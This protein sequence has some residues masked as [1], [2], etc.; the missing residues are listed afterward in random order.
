MLHKKFLLKSV[1]KKCGQ[2]LISGFP[3]AGKST[4]I[5]K[6][7]DSKISIVSQKIQTTNQT[8]RGV[9][10]KNNCQLIFYDTPGIVRQKKYFSKKLSR[11]VFNNSESIDLNLFVLDSTLKIN[12][13][14]IKNIKK[15]I[16]FFKRNFL[17]VNKTDLISNE[18]L[19]N[20]IKLIHNEIKF[21]EI[22]P[23][24]AKKK[25]GL[26][27]LLDKIISII[28][29]RKWIFNNLTLS[30]KEMEF[31]LSEITREKIFWLSNQEIPYSIRLVTKIN[32]KKN[33]NLVNQTIFVNKESQK[34]ILIGKKGLKIK[35]IGTSARIEMQEFLKKKVFL[36]LQVSVERKK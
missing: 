10:N 22:F 9:L 28:P 24:S 3:N 15:T 25:R 5:N 11:D 33:I 16:S 13:T 29:E 32:K 4:L 2:I 36:D 19:L 30:K 18:K 8:I 27:E 12:L 6:L 7:I 20:Q 21:D 23:I 1:N 17:I 14:Q 34:A 26:L 31:K 35:K